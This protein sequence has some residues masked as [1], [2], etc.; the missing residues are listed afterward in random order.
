MRKGGL[1]GG[2]F[3]DGTVRWGFGSV[4][5]G[6]TGRP[7]FERFALGRVG[8]VV[9][10]GVEALFWENDRLR[11]GLE[12]GMAWWGVFGQDVLVTDEIVSVVFE[13]GMLRFGIGCW[14]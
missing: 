8:V 3:L 9:M 4:C 10:V 6:K 2:G 13:Q 12:G 11:V 5:L 1:V 7:G 14:F